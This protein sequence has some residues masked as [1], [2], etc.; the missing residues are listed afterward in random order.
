MAE[1][2]GRYNVR[3]VREREVYESYMGILRIS[4]Y[5]ENAEDD[6]TP[7]LKDVSGDV[8]L[9]PEMYKPLKTVYAYL[10]D[11]DGNN[12]GVTYKPHFY[13]TIV[14]SESKSKTVKM[15]HVE[16]SIEKNIFAADT[17]N[18][19]GAINITSGEFAPIQVYSGNSGSTKIVVQPSTSAFDS[20]YFNYPDSNGNKFVSS[21][22]YAE[23]QSKL[24]KKSAAN[25]DRIS[26]EH[27]K[28]AG[29]K[30]TYSNRNGELIP[31]LYTR[32][33]ILGHGHSQS[34]DTNYSNVV[35]YGLSLDSSGLTG[36]LEPDARA[37]FTKLNWFDF[38]KLV[39]NNLDKIL[40]GDTRHRTGRYTQ[41]DADGTGD[42][43]RSLL[44]L[45]HS[46]ADYSFASTDTVGPA[47]AY[48]L[49]ETSPFIGQNV[50]VGS[51]MYNA[52]PFQRY[53]FYIAKQSCTNK[54]SSDV[55][56][57]DITE[58]VKP[59]N[60]KDEHFAS[61][62]VKNFVLCDGKDITQH[63]YIALDPES[64]ALKNPEIKIYTALKGS[65]PSNTLATIPLIHFN[66][67]SSMLLRGMVW[68]RA[69]ETG[70]TPVAIWD[71][72]EP[73]SQPSNSTNY[74]V[75]IDENNYIDKTGINKV[76]TYPYNVS[77]EYSIKKHKHYLFSSKSGIKNNIH[78]AAKNNFLIT[79]YHAHCRGDK[80][81]S[82]S[83]TYIVLG[84]SPS[85]F[86]LDKYPAASGNGIARRTGY[87]EV[88]N[89]RREAFIQYSDGLNDI[90]YNS[91]PI[92][93][94]SF[95]KL[96]N[97]GYTASEYNTNDLSLIK[98]G[99]KIEKKAFILLAN[100]AESRAPI[101]FE[102]GN[103]KETIYNY[104]TRREGHNGKGHKHKTKGYSWIIVTGA[105]SI[106]AAAEAKG[107]NGTYGYTS[108][109]IP[110][111]E[112]LGLLKPG[113]TEKNGMLTVADMATNTQVSKSVKINNGAKTIDVF[114]S[115][116]SAPSLNFIPVMRI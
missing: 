99:Q 95:T 87:P 38:D 56:D 21:H 92:K 71:G 32:D 2:Y 83:G 60:I 109:E 79:G 25:F 88:Y 111:G 15:I 78:N 22:N 93:N 86:H 45:E 14:E 46:W 68:E 33:K 116:L 107:Y 39:W 53:F 98:S 55:F 26:S 67:M 44:Q 13:D 37:K 66:T 5:G 80:T 47:G 72:A 100:E 3:N 114:T 6:A 76:K 27:V 49:T 10:S 70:P 42:I 73:L 19:R 18:I 84:T 82:P 103:P 24:F 17:F 63:N 36:V 75:G 96:W 62:L 89:Q 110:N 115:E 91:K 31:A 113:A 74:K 20:E 34:C 105:Y 40:S 77:S 41:L 108:L 85:N 101:A 8:I 35:K 12:L 65:S 64:D 4:P 97:G 43:R 11:S 57:G 81:I 59:F 106:G 102:G 90:W 58:T 28:V 16:S 50:Q 30:V 51:I 104:W 52:M 23:L 7:L 29:K 61:N 48:T 69:Y 9:N 112:K 1:K 54:T 94:W